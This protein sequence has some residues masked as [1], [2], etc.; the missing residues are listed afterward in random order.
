VFRL[1][2]ASILGAGLLIS[3]CSC[4]S[5]TNY[6]PVI[7]A[8]KAPVEQKTYIVQPGDTLYSIAWAFGLDFR[9]LVDINNLKSPYNVS[10][11]QTLYLVSPSSESALETQ[12]PSKSS[13]K[14]RQVTFAV[15]PKKTTQKS[16]THW[17]TKRVSS[18]LMPARGKVVN[19][20]STKYG[21]SGKGLEIHGQ[22]GETI[23]AA[24]KGT[25]VYSGDGLR[26]YGNLL[27]IKHNDAY[28]SAY[29]F[30]QKVFV[31]AGDQVKQG[32]KIA[33]MGKDGRGKPILYFEIRRFGKPVNPKQYLR[34]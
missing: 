3:L 1:L 29:A 7:E 23:K 18:W 12:R 11:G 22:A 2:L 8:G 30:N 17:Q 9:Q 14:K 34:Y 26:S 24:A 27:L 25:V 32:Q 5:R 15:L 33:T 20:F 31:K 4:I 6:A 28:L 16:T 10:V 21:S 13:A 19:V